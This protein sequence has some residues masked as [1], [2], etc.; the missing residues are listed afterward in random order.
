MIDHEIRNAK[1]FEFVNLEIDINEI[2]ISKN[3]IILSIKEKLDV[4][5]DNRV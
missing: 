3:K 1:S 4:V 2:I 5:L